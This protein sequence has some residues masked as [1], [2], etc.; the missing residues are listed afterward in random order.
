VK[1]YRGSARA[2]RA[3]VE[4]DHSR[5]DDY[6]LAEG[7]G[8][9]TRYVAGPD[10]VSLAGALT[11][12]AYEQ[13]V[14]GHDINTGH[15]KGRLRD[16]AN[17]LRFVEVTIN[18]PK[19]WSLAA[20]L[21]PE[22]SAALDAAQDRAAEQIIGWI[23][24]HATTRVGPRGRQVQVPVTEIEAA[25]I[26]HYTSRAGDPHRH[27]HL[28]VNARVFVEGKWR[29]LHSVGV[30]DMI[31]AIN[32]IGHAAVATD[33]QFRAVLA[34]HGF[35]MD[36]TDG[37]GG[38]G[39]LVELAP[40]VG[41]FS[42][43]A[44]QIRRNIDR[45][46]AEW[47]T[48]HPEEEPG[49]R[50]REAWDRRAWAQARPDKPNKLAP[51]DGA[52]MV[53][54][55]NRLLHDLGY[56]DPTQVGLPIPPAGPS[57]GS[58]DRDAIAELVIAQLGAE[59]SA[60]NTADIRGRVEQH[61]AASGLITDAV[62]RI[63]LAEDITAR[64]VARCVSLI[65]D[66]GVPE[67][68]RSLTS[69][70]V[71]DVE[72][73]LVAA[74]AQRAQR[75]GAPANLTVVSA[76]LDAAQR[77]AVA[78]LAGTG[79]LVVVEGAAGAGKTTALAA[80]RD[81]LAHQGRRMVVVTPTL[82]AAQVA[83]KETGI[84]STSAAG[85]AHEFGWQWDEAGHW[86][87][88]SNGATSATAVLSR[89]DLLLVDEAGMLDQDTALAL[90][91]IADQTGARVALMGDRH[92]LPAVGRGGVLDLATRWAHPDTVVGLDVVHR[93][94]DP[95]YAAISLAMR[96]GEHVSEIFDQLWDRG[97]IQ[98]HATEPERLHAIATDAADHIAASGDQTSDVVVMADT[99]AQVSVLNGIIR[100][101]LVAR[102]MVDDARAVTTNAGERIGVGDRIATRLNDHH[103][104]VANRD[105]WTV[106]AIGADGSLTLA[107][108]AHN[109]MAGVSG[110]AAVRDVPGWYVATRVELAYATTVY[111]AQ[112][113]TTSVGHMLL[114][115]TTTGS[116]A[117]VGMT[118]GRQDNV[119][120]LVAENVD[121]A[122]SIW[123]GV[124]GRD[125]ADLGP[126][127]AAEQAAEE[128]E[129][130]APQRPTHVVLD[131]L[132]QAWTRQAD[133]TED[134]QDLTRHRDDI[135][136]V[137]TI[138]AQHEPHARELLHAERAAAHRH[139]A[140]AEALKALE[141]K[142][143]SE[144]RDLTSDLLDHW[145]REHVNAYQAAAVLRA[146]SGRLGQHRRQVRDAR[147]D[148]TAWAQRWQPI[149]P[150]LPTDPDQI[151]RQLA[152]PPAEMR[153][154]QLRQRIADTARQT[155]AR[156]HPEAEPIRT[157]AAAAQSA[158]REAEDALTAH[159]TALGEQL[160]PYRWGYVR[161]DK[162]PRML[163]EVRS[164][165]DAIGT[166]LQDADARVEQL[167][168]SPEIRSLPS[169]TIRTEHDQ[170]G[171]DRAA[172]REAARVA[173]AARAAEQ[174]RL[175]ADQARRRSIEPSTYS[176][177]PTQGPTMGF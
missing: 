36:T 53:A 136:A 3:Y 17:A 164:D 47:R 41:R 96:H 112:G 121:E 42:A 156:T 111:G 106:T 15:A 75:P 48:T 146:G 155:V 117:Y 172:A 94:T 166:R 49:P 175:E 51:V 91:Q 89:G 61:L 24:Q 18:G 169:D 153:G 109:R 170:W 57:I 124:M 148:L 10:G 107:P 141:A 114:S 108:A 45:Y 43:R 120:H 92:Q 54:A 68:I 64:A 72:A 158:A 98:L 1:F 165:L 6:Y 152:E 99:L 67:H 125:R 132:R 27:L 85:L 26:R 133:L 76:N 38:M 60:W 157:E 87:Q 16:D 173:A 22:V 130:Y 115:E 79:Q 37:R 55:W 70:R 46:E 71:L 105:L 29:G 135:E 103:L 12:D 84:P 32:G 142:V 151:T 104:G 30:R 88:D 69:Q 35:T 138:R 63:E 113:E 9:A 39:E 78:V 40:Y 2:A 116:A 139:S 34:A 123:T 150:N 131:R 62:V 7:S 73:D 163:A 171:A 122:R 11:G 127:H 21:Y 59:H 110:G 77:D 74:M 174:R 176:S 167:L 50:L 14:A 23:A 81:R 102:G 140:A 4:A 28:Q 137:L 83:T 8:V 93:F 147:A 119:A 118:R 33:P 31:E 177:R 82:K 20:A 160:R 44:N 97:Q 161:A 13:W 168:R 129:R 100:D 101:Q 65:A 80:V 145:H 143:A 19:T 144:Q 5:A 149:L 126:A 52:A 154:D 90:F 134:A 58:L 128:M 56:R 162:L 95:N 159:A 86:R 25:V 66:P